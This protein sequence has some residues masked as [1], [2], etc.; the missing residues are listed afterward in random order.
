MERYINLLFVFLTS[1]LKSQVEQLT[2]Q[3][4]DTHDHVTSLQDELDGTVA[5]SANHQEELNAKTDD[6]IRLDEKVQ[7]LQAALDRERMKKVQQA[8]ALAGGEG[9]TGA[10]TETLRRE[11]LSKTRQIE[12][13]EEQL[14]RN[15]SHKL[16]R[17]RKGAMTSLRFHCLKCRSCYLLN[18]C[19]R[20]QGAAADSREPSSCQRN[21][22]L[23][24]WSMATGERWR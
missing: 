18:S 17:M 1:D 13:L 9:S 5:S 20:E 12:N 22:A 2:S 19:R 24:S 21:P 11:L 6:V 16:Q 7:R 15:T 8:G 3:L 4:H 10:E 14:R 23:G